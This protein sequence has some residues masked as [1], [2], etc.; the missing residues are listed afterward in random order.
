MFIPSYLKPFFVLLMF[1]FCIWNARVEFNSHQTEKRSGVRILFQNSSKRKC[2]AIS[3][4]TWKPF[5]LEKNKSYCPGKV[6]WNKKWER[7]W[8]RIFLLWR[9]EKKREWGR[10]YL[11][12]HVIRTAWCK[13]SF[14]VFGNK[15]IRWYDRLIWLTEPPGVAETVYK[16]V[17]WI[18]VLS[19]FESLVYIL[20]I[21]FVRF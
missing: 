2:N 17:N 1:F 5:F 9:K 19:C 18:L 16:K 4:F 14:N 7:E 20:V 6:W 10:I 3:S 11:L 13:D 15:M 8:E 12:R 21:V